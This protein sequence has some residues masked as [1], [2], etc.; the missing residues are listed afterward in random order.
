MC[1]CEGNPDKCDNADV[2]SHPAAHI[3]C[4][5]SSD[6]DDDDDNDDIQCVYPYQSLSG[7]ALSAYSAY[8]V[9]EEEADNVVLLNDVEMDVGSS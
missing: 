1:R 2:D 7:D 8:D 3:E 4:E 6:D 9:Q 5:E